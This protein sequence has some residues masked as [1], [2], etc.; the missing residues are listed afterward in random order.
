MFTELIIRLAGA[1]DAH[2]IPYMLIGGQAVLVHGE[3]RMTR[4]V[5]VTLGVDIDRLDA[6]LRAVG[7]AQLTPLV[8][9]ATFV[10]ETNVLPC[11]GGDSGIRVDLI[12]SFSP[13]ERQAID[14]AVSRR[15]GSLDVRF[16]SVEDLII[17]KLVA[18]R[19][20]DLDDAA[21]VLLKNPGLNRTHV[22]QWLGQFEA[23]LGEPFLVRWQSIQ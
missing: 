7:A 14:R 10:K 11:A 3:P 9:P 15:L 2:G 13:F 12:F 8:D 20:R 6:V 5:D 16:I 4:D 17:Q 23:A 1:L 19:P 21:N 18:G 22:E